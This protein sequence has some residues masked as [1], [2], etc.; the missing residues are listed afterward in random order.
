MHFFSRENLSI[1]VVILNTL[2]QASRLA[3][4]NIS[5]CLYPLTNWNKVCIVSLTKF[6]LSF[7]QFICQTTKEYQKPFLSYF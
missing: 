2:L 5:K 6:F 3:D 4:I 1:D 7:L